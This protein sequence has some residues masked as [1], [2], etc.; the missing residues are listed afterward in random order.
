MLGVERNVMQTA[1]TKAEVRIAGQVDTHEL[2][3]LIAERAN[4]LAQR[5]P[6][7]PGGELKLWLEAEA[8]VKRER[9]GGVGRAS[10]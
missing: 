9:A 2:T 5:R 8:A 3:L 6:L 1:G 10:C 4:Q 7:E